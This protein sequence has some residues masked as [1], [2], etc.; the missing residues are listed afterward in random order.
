MSRINQL[1]RQ[2]RKN[3]ELYYNGNPEVDDDVFDAWVDEL[4]TAEPDNAA[5]FEVGAPVDDNSHWEVIEHKIPMTSLDKVNTEAELRE[6]LRQRPASAYCVQEKMDG[7]SNS[8]EYNDG[9]LL[10]AVTR[11]GG[12]KG[13]D[14]TRNVLKMNGADRFSVDN[15]TPHFIRGEIMMFAD[16]FDAFNDVCVERKWRDEPYKNAR[17]GA[18]GT[19]RRLDGVGSEFLTFVAYDYFD[20][21]DLPDILESRTLE[22]LEE[23]GYKVP[24]Y[25]RVTS[26][27]RI[28]EIYN[29]YVGSKRAN[30]P[31]E[32]DG[33]VIKV[34]SKDEA[35]RL[36]KKLQSSTRS[37]KNPKSAVAWK[38]EAEARETKLV[39]IEWNLGKGG[40]VTPIALL[41]PIELGGVTVKRASLHNW[42]NVKALNLAPNCD[43]LVKRANDVIPQVVKRT[44]SLEIRGFFAAPA[45]C[46]SCS[47]D[48]VWDNKYLECV[49]PLCEALLAGTIRRWVEKIEVKFFGESVINALV[50]RK[51]VFN[52]ADIY[53]LTQ[54]DIE[55]ATSPGI[56]KRAY[57]NLHAKKVIPLSIAIGSLG[58]KSFG[59]SLA[60]MMVEAGYDTSDKMLAA[61]ESQIAS[62]EQFGEERGRLI[63][64]GLK[65]NESVIKNLH[66]VLE[67]VEGPINTQANNGPLSG[68]S[69][70]ITGK[71]SRTKKEFEAVITEA[72]G[73][74]KT[75]VRRG[76]DFLIIADVGSTSSKAKSAKALGITL[77][78]EGEFDEMA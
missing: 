76:L 13:E 77:I 55:R 5:L 44:D 47:N 18:S 56:A 62:I 45:S 31:Y 35:A 67:I 6:W 52:I 34:D 72:G 78:S 9:K 29:E 70:C 54:A 10:R 73:E 17:N 64:E 14:I 25:E 65:K 63:V 37:G 23:S 49:N 38:F 19:A 33:L 40:R 75:S 48:L 59:R 60:R 20:G 53:K 32:I 61:T 58:I 50:E 28:V 4:R 68:K 24:F 66:R 3:R 27:D 21:M 57:N 74:Y 22:M 43:V 41:E 42:D 1:E 7:I 71:L 36:E 46:P 15:I 39:G 51:M 30:L 8:L 16:D 26:I 12:D 2:I 11:G 69:F